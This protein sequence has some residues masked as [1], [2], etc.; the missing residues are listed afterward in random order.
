MKNHH[1]Y[2]LAA[3]REKAQCLIWEIFGVGTF[4]ERYQ[5]LSMWNSNAQ[6]HERGGLDQPGGSDQRTNIPREWEIYYILREDEKAKD[7][8]NSQEHPDNNRE[9]ACQ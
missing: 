6:Q 5:Y 3:F 7:A 4:E 2:T 9:S 1:N 8:K